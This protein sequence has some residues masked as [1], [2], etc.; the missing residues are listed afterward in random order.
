ME[1]NLAFSDSEVEV[2]KILSKGLRLYPIS[3]VPCKRYE[4]KSCRDLHVSEQSLI[5]AQ[6]TL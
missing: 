4:A 3:M 5:A 2:I 6:F 1:M